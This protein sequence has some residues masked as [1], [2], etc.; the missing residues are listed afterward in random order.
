MKIEFWEKAFEGSIE[1]IDDIIAILSV[2]DVEFR[3]KF[4]TLSKE[5]QD[6]ELE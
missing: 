6:L 4:N 2:D 1:Y 3:E 5:Y